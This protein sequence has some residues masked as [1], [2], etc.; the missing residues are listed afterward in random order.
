MEPGPQ[1]RSDEI[2]AIHIFHKGRRFLENLGHIYDWITSQNTRNSPMPG[3]PRRCVRFLNKMI[4]EYSEPVENLVNELL[5]APNQDQSPKPTRKFNASYTKERPEFEPII[6]NSKARL[7]RTHHGQSSV[8]HATA[9]LSGTS[10]AEGKLTEFSTHI[11]RSSVAPQQ[12]TQGPSEPAQQILSSLKSA[13]P[14]EEPLETSKPIE[15]PLETSKPIEEPLKSPPAPDHS[16]DPGPINSV[17]ETSQLLEPK[18]YPHLAERT[19]NTVLG[20]PARQN[21]LH[22]SA[23]VRPEALKSSWAPPSILAQRVH[24]TYSASTPDFII[25]NMSTVKYKP[26]FVSYFT[27]IWE[28]SPEVSDVLYHVFNSTSKSDFSYQSKSVGEILFFK[29]LKN[30]ELNPNKENAIILIA[31]ITLQVA[32]TK[33]PADEASLKY[34]EPQKVYFASI[35]TSKNLLKPLFMLSVIQPET[36]ARLIKVRQ[37]PEHSSDFEMLLLVEEDKVLYSKNKCEEDWFSKLA[38]T[39]RVALLEK[40]SKHEKLS[41]AFDA[42]RRAATRFLVFSRA[43]DQYHFQIFT[44]HPDANADKV[45]PEF[46]FEHELLDFDHPQAALEWN[47]HF[48]DCFFD[49][50]VGV[51]GAF[52]LFER[53]CGE[54]RSHQ[55]KF[56]VLDCSELVA[57]TQG[58]EIC[59]TKNTKLS[60]AI[61]SSK[62]EIVDKGISFVI[63]DIDVFI[64]DTAFIPSVKRSE[65]T[66]EHKGTHYYLMI[67]GVT[68]TNKLFFLILSDTK[69]LY[70]RLKLV[71]HHIELGPAPASYSKAAKPDWSQYLSSISDSIYIEESQNKLTA[72]VTVAY[73]NAST[74]EAEIDLTQ[75]L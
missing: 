22:C 74:F 56:A 8:L 62:D 43:G 3:L 48:T 40:Q 75:Y 52:G 7:G 25:K 63:G 31:Q 14:I 13:K 23:S 42:V 36:A 60:F 64:R 37:F 30:R 49:S 2:T 41:L 28:S 68:G 10:Q 45:A 26:K 6:I 27:H 9:L 24:K 20:Q 21:K 67:Y 53:R 5:E 58:H 57:Q 70:D 32:K 59:D 71:S 17:L 72:T 12:T 18:N 51:A 16:G 46:N 19:E 66:F 33:Q 1:L 44:V 54:A 65:V 50:N 69:G 47:G 35:S 29:A 39:H 11:L 38:D 61:G 15:E 4:K 73:E 55:L 34:P